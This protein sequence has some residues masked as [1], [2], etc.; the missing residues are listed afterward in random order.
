MVSYRITELALEQHRS[1]V[2]ER[3]DQRGS[4]MQDVFAPGHAA[5]RQPDFILAHMQQGAA[6]D[7]LRRNLLLG[8]I[9][10]HRERCIARSHTARSAPGANP[11]TS[12]ARPFTDISTRTSPC[13]PIGAAS[14][15]ASKYISL[16]TRR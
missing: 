3:Q 9:R 4:G 10:A 12:T 16:T 8:E 1:V 11:S 14:V 2:E 5:V 15:G 13:G 6:V 7:D